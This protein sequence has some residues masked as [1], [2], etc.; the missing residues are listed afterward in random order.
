MITSYEDWER[1]QRRRKI[2]STVIAILFG[3]IVI[4]M[5]V[6]DAW[7]GMGR[8]IES[9]DDLMRQRCRE[10]DKGITE[11]MTKYCNGLPGV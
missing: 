11:E 9:R 4:G 7:Y 1:R 2:R 8:E 5:L 3:I 6:A 10:W